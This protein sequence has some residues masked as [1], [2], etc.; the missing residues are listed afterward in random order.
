DAAEKMQNAEAVKV[1][2]PNQLEDLM[3]VMVAGAA[4][5]EVTSSANSV[6]QYSGSSAE[7]RYL[8]ED[9]NL[10]VKVADIG[11]MGAMAA[12]GT[13][14]NVNS[15]R[16]TGDSYEK[17]T[18]ENG[19]LVSESYDADTKH[20]KYSVLVAERILIEAEGDNVEMATLKS[21]VDAVGIA[22]AEKLIQ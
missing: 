18:T 7:A 15:S 3:P 16:K 12:L 1:V 21:A 9:G 2:D 6:G 19:R 14:M 11:A 8:V 5:G 20:G 22:R 10:S 13:A 17:I 4:R